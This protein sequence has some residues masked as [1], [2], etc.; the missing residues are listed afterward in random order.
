MSSHPDDR[1]DDV[2]TGHVTERLVEILERRLAPEEETEIDAHLRGC[3]KCA[4]DIA[5]ARSLHE[6]GSRKAKR[7]LSAERVLAL[8]TEPAARATPEEQVHLSSCGSCRE[9]IAL[10]KCMPD[11]AELGGAPAVALSRPSSRPSRSG[12]LGGWRWVVWAGVTAGAVAVVMLATHLG[13]DE[14][15]LHLKALARIEPLAAD[16]PRSVPEPGS[17]EEAWNLALE[18]YAEG[19][20]VAAETLLERASALAPNRAEVA[21]YLGSARLLLGRADAASEGLRRATELALSGHLEEEA[22][23][24]LA[25]A[26]LAAGKR[27]EAEES[28]RAVISMDRVHR[29]EAELLLSRLAR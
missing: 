24:Q 12:F 7:H 13:H 22:Q 21:L 23:W 6:E 1:G 17:F 29:P 20:Y 28:L 26:C 19:D 2:G 14:D 5:L 4:A 15:V 16:V 3:R 18:Q 8:A 10:E 11:P 25:N 9:E 27:R